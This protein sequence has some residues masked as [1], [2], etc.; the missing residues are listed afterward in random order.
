MRKAFTGASANASEPSE[1]VLFPYSPMSELVWSQTEGLGIRYASHSESGKASLFWSTESFNIVIPSTNNLTEE[2]KI[3]LHLSSEMA[4]G[5]N[6]A[7]FFSA[8][9]SLSDVLPV[10]LVRHQA[11]DSSK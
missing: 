10:S 8:H 3:Q 2:E 6:I 7:G 11:R 1:M 5:R 4:S 9:R